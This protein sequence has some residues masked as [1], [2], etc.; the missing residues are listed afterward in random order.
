MRQREERARE[1]ERNN[2]GGRETKFYAESTA[3]KRGPLTAAFFDALRRRERGPTRV[4][5]GEGERGWN[6]YR[7]NGNLYIEKILYKYKI[8]S[9]LRTGPSRV[10]PY[11]TRHIFHV[12]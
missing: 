7:P 10:A 5:G 8:K 6:F 11:R 2:G 9:G 3:W 12:A 1:R 4:V